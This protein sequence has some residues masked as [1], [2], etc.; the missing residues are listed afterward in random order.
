MMLY[1]FT[2]S[3][4]AME[5]AKISTSSGFRGGVAWIA[6]EYILDTYPDRYPFPNDTRDVRVQKFSRLVFENDF[7]EIKLATC[8]VNGNSNLYR[9]PNDVDML[10]ATVR[11]WKDLNLL[12]V[13]PPLVRLVEETNGQIAAGLISVF[14]GDALTEFADMEAFENY[15]RVNNQRII[16]G[17]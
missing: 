13:A 17:I 4:L 9:V 5:M 12:D 7:N 1:D 10:V 3:P 6:N 11:L 15:S 2:G 8:G 14:A 16:R